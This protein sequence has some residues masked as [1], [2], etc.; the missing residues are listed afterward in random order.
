MAMTATE[1]IVT[2]GAAS[3]RRRGFP[4]RRGRAAGLPWILPTLILSVGFIYYCVGYTG[5][6]SLYDWNGISPNPTPVGAD[7]YA[8]LAGDGVVLLT[9]RHTVIY[10]VVT[11]VVEAVVGF[12]FAAML[13]SRVKLG[14]VYKVL[15]FCPVII[16]PSVMA[17][18]FRKI[19]AADGEV[20][21]VLEL[22]GLGA[23]AQPWLAQ[24]STALGVIILIGIWER[25]GLYFILYFA[26]MS[27]VDHEMIEA[28]WLDGAGNIRVLWSVVR[29]SVAGTTVALLVLQAIYTLKLFDV[30]F[31]VSQGGPSFSTEFLGTYIYRQGI[32]QAHVGYAAAL[33]I[34]L[35]VIALVLTLG[36]NTRRRREGSS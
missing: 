3:R 20:N 17:P 16:A 23:L 33:S 21:Q 19:F 24:S 34:L 28:A 2:G 8:K 15:V 30:P 7:N 35:L 25:T 36:L 9:L 18:V 1:T 26:A 14:I 31:L 12:V 27:Q 22:V 4:R 13:H 32:T 5:M 11:F 10:I 6:I 29:P